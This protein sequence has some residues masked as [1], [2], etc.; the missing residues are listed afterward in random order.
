MI[1]TTMMCPC[2]QMTIPVNISGKRKH[3]AAQPTTTVIRCPLPEC[4]GEK[5]IQH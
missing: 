3:P 5:V 2:G 4:N 1:K